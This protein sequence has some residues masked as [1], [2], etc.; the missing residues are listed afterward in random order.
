MKDPRQMTDY[1]LVQARS[2]FQQD[3]LALRRIEGIS[4]TTIKVVWD[5]SIF[6]QNISK[7]T[8]DVKLQSNISINILIFCLN[9][10][11]F[12]LAFLLKVMTDYNEYLEGVKIWYNGT[13]LNWRNASSEEALTLNA[14]AD[15]NLCFVN[16]TLTT[17]HNSGSSSH[18]LTGLMPYTQYDVFLMPF[19]KMLL[20]KPSNLM[21]GNT[22]EDG[23][24]SF[25]LCN[26]Y[27][28]LCFNY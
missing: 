16:G 19:Y 15:T 4:P 18:V 21:T 17:V 3:V 14:S 9:N 20:G 26:Y 27:F 25:I 23:T 24:M 5:V 2:Y 6:K 8:I 10:N 13:S 7:L 11:L 12:T 28:L 22:N 1:E